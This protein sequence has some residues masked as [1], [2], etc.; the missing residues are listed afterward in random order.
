MNG[1]DLRILRKRL[2]ISQEE[3]GKKLGIT[4]G[5]VSRIETG[6]HGLRG[7]T[8]ILAEQLLENHSLLGGKE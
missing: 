2:Q 4:G 5:A 1:T 7:S 8:Q 6:R 3:L